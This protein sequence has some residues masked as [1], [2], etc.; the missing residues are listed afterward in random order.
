MTAERVPPHAIDA[1]RAIVAAVLMHGNEALDQCDNLHPTYF[2]SESCRRIFEAGLQVTAAGKPCD[3]VSIA[4]HLR[5]IN[6]LKQ[7]GGTPGLAELRDTVPD[8]LDSLPA[9]VETIREKWAQREANVVC[10]KIA[11]EAYGDIGNVQD[12]IDH[13]MSMLDRIAR[14]LIEGKQDEDTITFMSELTT[15]G[16]ELQAH[17]KRRFVT[18]GIDDL[19]EDLGGLEY[20]FVTVLG[21]PTNWGKSGTVVMM[22]DSALRQGKRVLIVTFEDAPR[23]YIRRLLARRGRINAW[24]LKNNQLDDSE[25]SGFMSATNDFCKAQ[26]EPV[27]LRAIGKPIELV[28][29]RVARL[30]K[31]TPY[32]LIV[33]DYLQAARSNIHHENTRATINHCLRQMMDVI[34]INGA[35]GLIVSQF[36]RLEPGQEPWL[37]SLKE[38]GDIE[39]GAEAVLLGFVDKAQCSR[40][41]L[42]K[43]KDGA[44]ML[45]Y[46]LK[47]DASSAS[48]WPGSRIEERK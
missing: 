12:F 10:R 13:S 44:K 33:F 32:D 8:R 25:W 2:Y 41:R 46:G 19:D 20:G 21:A 9:Y 28:V 16:K 43:S 11:A 3:I 40:L 1:E 42:A 27:I 35:A 34:K 36:A 37:S 29:R 38:S 14:E 17:T 39:N 26:P 31:A 45:D 7:V 47:W 5:D 24:R 22:T 4:E 48:M 15:M 30:C 23:L 6:R 18:T